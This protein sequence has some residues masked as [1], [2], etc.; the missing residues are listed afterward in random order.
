[1]QKPKIIMNVAAW[2]KVSQNKYRSNL[3]FHEDESTF[4]IGDVPVL[5]VPA[6]NEPTSTITL[7][8]ATGYSN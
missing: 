4:Y 1:M 3:H 6:I 2:A 7:E 5:V 8:D